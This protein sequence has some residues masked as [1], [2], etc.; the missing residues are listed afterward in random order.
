MWYL[1]HSD[2][3]SPERGT[4]VVD[5]L[6]TW[7]PC[8]ILDRLGLGGA[9]AHL[10]G[11]RLRMWLRQ[12]RPD[13]VVL[14]DGLGRRVIESVRPPPR[15]VVRHNEA[16]PEHL[17]MEP[18]PVEP[19]DADLVIVPYGH[20]SPTVVDSPS[21]V[22]E[23]LTAARSRAAG[24]MAEAAAMRSVRRRYRL[25]EDQ[26]LVVGWGDDG[27]LDGPDL[28]IR[29]LWTLEHHQGVSAHGVWFGLTS[30]RNEVE[31]LEVEARRCGL[32]DRF[33][34]RSENDIEGHMCGDGV[35][36]PYRSAGSDT[37]LEDLLEIACS[38]SLVVTFEASPADDPL[39]RRIANLD[40]EPA[41]ATMAEGLEADRASRSAAARL[42]FE[43]L[44]R[45]ILALGS[46]PA[47]RR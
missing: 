31:R 41:A 14:D 44:P 7:P 27:W 18:S 39:I 34:H 8:A 47:R 2:A 9:A 1:R 15:I 16:P 21:T 19:A 38:G 28:F 10:R 24:R 3:R 22:E 11:L 13:V 25:P 4:R 37:E 35:F 6:R 23:F 40:L 36:L 46:E 20:S 30:D 32:G 5:S 33:H 29:F 26:P 12:V 17:H 43:A 45:D 42:R